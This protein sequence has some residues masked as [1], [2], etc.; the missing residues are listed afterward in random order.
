MDALRACLIVFVLTATI[1]VPRQFQLEAVLATLNGQDSVITAGTGSGKTL[2]IIIP[3]L[4]RPGTI[5]MTI[6]PLKCL[7]AT[8]VL[9][10]TKYGIP[11]IS[12]NEDT[13]AD[14]ALWES[15]RVGK[16]T[17]L[18]V[19]PEQLS[20]FN[21]HLPR[22]TRLLRQDQTFTRRIKHVLDSEIEL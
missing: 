20:M 22:L 4:L 3:I 17:H 6:S 7:Q 10:S 16:F 8:Q 1:I 14:P 9:K 5:S 19:S 18:I 13:A 2:C 12:I 21:G 15:I 11:T